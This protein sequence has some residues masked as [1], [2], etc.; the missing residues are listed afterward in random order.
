ME[1]SSGRTAYC[2]SFSR[3]HRVA[4]RGEGRRTGVAHIVLAERFNFFRDLFVLGRSTEFILVS[5]SANTMSGKQKQPP[6]TNYFEKK[7][8]AQPKVSNHTDSPKPQPISLRSKQ[9][10]E[11][12]GWPLSRNSR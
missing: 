10:Q 6:I 8:T 2:G 1:S 9:D 11:A 3:T 4:T 5:A 7:P 12:L